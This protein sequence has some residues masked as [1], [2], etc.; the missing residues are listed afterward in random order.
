[1][2]KTVKNYNRKRTSKK[3]YRKTRKVRTARYIRKRKTKRNKIIKRTWKKLY[4]LGGMEGGEPQRT[5]Q[6]PKLVV[7]KYQFTT[8]NE[9]HPTLHVLFLGKEDTIYMNIKNYDVK[10]MILFK[11]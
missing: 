4:Q 7:V 1:M 6:E 3:K 10:V 2:S 8:E 11:A 5:R 9:T